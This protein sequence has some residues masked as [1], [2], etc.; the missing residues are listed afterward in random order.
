MMWLRSR[1][2]RERQSG[3][4]TIE[5][6]GV[7]V[8]ISVL[9]ASLAVAPVAPTLGTAI[10]DT[11][12]KVAQ[13]VLGGTCSSSNGDEN[14]G[15]DEAPQPYADHMMECPISSTS[16][17]KGTTE[18]AMIFTTK[19]GMKYK[20]KKNSDG[21]GDI[22]VLGYGGYGG[23]VEAGKLKFGDRVKVNA[24]VGEDRTLSVGSVYHLDS[25]EE[26]D[27]FAEQIQ[28][29]SDSWIN[30]LTIG[31]LISGYKV[32]SL[33]ES[34]RSSVMEVDLEHWGEAGAGADVNKISDKIGKRVKKLFG[35]DPKDSGSNND[36][37]KSE[38]YDSTGKTD[39][40]LPANIVGAI[41]AVD[42]IVPK[43]EGRVSTSKKALVEY[44]RGSNP[45]DSS[46][47]L[48]AVTVGLE[49]DIDGS[50]K[51]IVDGGG[52][53]GADKAATFLVDTDFNLVGLKMIQADRRGGGFGD[54]K[55]DNTEDVVVGDFDMTD[56]QTRAMAMDFLLNPDK[57]SNLQDLA[58]GNQTGATPEEKALG[59][60][61]KSE[62]LKLNEMTL[63]NTNDSGG[64][65][66]GAKLFG[67][68]GGIDL[69]NFSST[70]E[71][72]DAYTWVPDEDGGL[73]RV[74]NTKC[75]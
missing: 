43:L 63:E 28:D 5:Y 33:P 11:V 46:D 36:G 40:K 72:V 54:A 15:S 74:K 1:L 47:D 48:I 44:D 20:V 52:N 23:N 60:L 31:P 3:Q 50:G 68:G 21:T 12:C 73:K 24:G 62:K 32:H 29:I 7:A 25:W 59:E 17:S 4:G 6:L 66:L 69:E 56:P 41:S 71:L 45:D 22:T 70:S 13:P 8:L 65:G 53:A 26:T 67:V 42:K 10:K 34:P 64:F 30:H 49:D 2:V 18:N 55:D 16:G 39:Y 51:F 58:T 38:D 61:L 27:A 57:L 9:T 75:M 14:E 35:M 19:H 37:W